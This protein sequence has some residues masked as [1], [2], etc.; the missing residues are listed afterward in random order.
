MVPSVIMI[1]EPTYHTR[2]TSVPTSLVLHKIQ[3][4]PVFPTNIFMTIVPAIIIMEF[5]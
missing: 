3:A 5:N 1:V 2:H 4:V